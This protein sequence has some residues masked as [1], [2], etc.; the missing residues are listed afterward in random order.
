MIFFLVAKDF[1][2]WN[3]R[4]C[5]SETNATVKATMSIVYQL[6]QNAKGI[7]AVKPQMK[8]DNIF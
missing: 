2:L 8:K 6:S 4:S 3:C 7:T 1:Y 5:H